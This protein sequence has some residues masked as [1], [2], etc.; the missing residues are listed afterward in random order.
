MIGK[1]LI[2]GHR[3]STQRCNQLLTEKWGKRRKKRSR[4]HKTEG[5]ESIIRQQF[6]LFTIFP[7]EKKPD[8]LIGGIKFSQAPR[9]LKP[10]SLKLPA[11]KH[12]TRG[13]INEAD[14]LIFHLWAA[15]QL[16]AA[17]CTPLSPSLSLTALL[18]ILNAPQ[19][20]IGPTGRA[21]TLRFVM[22][23]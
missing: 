12:Q 23:I 18:M 5:L 1:Q 15:K 19:A 17:P 20:V 3:R 2:V 11:N 21:E 9:R 7:K 14:V 8:Y 4:S 16:T 10:T 22:R 13:S 6:F